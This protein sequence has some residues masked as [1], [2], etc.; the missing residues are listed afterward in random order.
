[1]PFPVNVKSQPLEKERVCKI[2]SSIHESNRGFSDGKK[3]SIDKVT[4]HDQEL[5]L[6]RQAYSQ[7][8]YHI[9]S[10]VA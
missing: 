6:G 9:S 3:K 10:T 8:L 7:V 2:P 5:N 1:M 4:L